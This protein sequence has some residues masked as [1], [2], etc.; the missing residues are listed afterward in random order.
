MTTADPELAL[1]PA[2]DHDDELFRRVYASTRSDEL[3]PLPW[4]AAEKHT[5]LAQQFA[6]QSAHYAAH[7]ADA[8]FDVIVVDGEPAGRLNVARRE[9]AILIV[10]ISL[11]PECRSRG[12]GTR[13]LRRLIEEA[14]A[15]GSR[16]RIHVERF[17]PA[18][19]LYERLGF[20]VVED[21]GVYLF[22]ERPPSA[23]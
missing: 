5:F 19:R 10:D 14:D 20:S 9:D 2:S 22:L 13:L 16:V 15:G 7:Y 1:R 3:A 23:R 6:A 4:S 11:L 21:E 17:N 8:T 12:L 18:L